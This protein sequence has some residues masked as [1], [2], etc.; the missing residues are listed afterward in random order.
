MSRR[1]GAHCVRK[2]Q[3]SSPHA[4]CLLAVH[5]LHQLLPS[6]AACSCRERMTFVCAAGACH[7]DCRQCAD[8]CH[9][10]EEWRGGSELYAILAVYHEHNHPPTASSAVLSAH[11]RAF[12]IPRDTVSEQIDQSNLPWCQRPRQV[13]C[14]NESHLRMLNRSVLRMMTYA[15][16]MCTCKEHTLCTSVKRS[17]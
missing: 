14:Q 17:M 16:A 7:P 13:F 4:Y 9:T 6:V 12:V 15:V 1:H 11:I 10:A 3:S 2:V 5:D 8:A